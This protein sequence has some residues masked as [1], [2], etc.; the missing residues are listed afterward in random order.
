MK[1]N[2]MDNIALIDLQLMD[3]D[4]VSE[5]FPEHEPLSIS[6][7]VALLENNILI[8]SRARNWK[9]EPAVSTDTLVRYKIELDYWKNKLQNDNYQD[10]QD[11]RIKYPGEREKVEAYWNDQAENLK[12]AITH[13]DGTV[14]AHGLARRIK[15]DLNLG[16][17]LTRIKDWIDFH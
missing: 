11:K 13:S 10:K 9:G 8:Y 12:G 1:A 16:A 6:D 14:N 4:Y 15:S 7:K 17:S 2:G 5:K 3:D